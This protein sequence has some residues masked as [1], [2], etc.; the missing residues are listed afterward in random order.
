[1]T[2]A[3]NFDS[4]NLKITDVIKLSSNEKQREIFKYLSELD[5]HNINAYNIAYTQLGSS[6]NIERSNGFKEWLEK[7]PKQ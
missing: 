4:L 5:D 1:M 6:F 7:Q 2:E 3:V